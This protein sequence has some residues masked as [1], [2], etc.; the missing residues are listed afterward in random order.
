MNIGGKF[1]RI[2]SSYEPQDFFFLFSRLHECDKVLRR[3]VDQVVKTEDQRVSSVR[4]ES[5]WMQSPMSGQFFKKKPP[6]NGYG[7]RTIRGKV[8]G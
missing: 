8:S 2:Y 1:R 5:L 6:S 3:L 4:R 7:F